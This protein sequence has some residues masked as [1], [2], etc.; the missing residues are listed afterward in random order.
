MLGLYAPLEARLASLDWTGTGVDLDER[1]RAHLLRADLEALGAR[2]DAPAFAE[3]PELRSIAAGFG[4]MYVVEGSTL[5]GRVI[6]RYVSRELGVSA[7]RGAS[8]FASHEDRVAAMWRAFGE[9]AS[10]YCTTEERAQEA[11]AAA[12]VTFLAFERWLGDA[13]FQEMS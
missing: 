11:L 12:K 1:R 5:G 3:P 4:C 2:A 13:D 8:F 9:A 6:L 10:A 7:A